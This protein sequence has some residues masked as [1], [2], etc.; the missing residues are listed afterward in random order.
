MKEKA[1]ENNNN[2]NS[3]FIDFSSLFQ[4]NYSSNGKQTED[5]YKL[6]INNTENLCTI[7]KTNIKKGISTYNKTDM[8]W[9][10]KTFGTNKLPPDKPLRIIDFILECFEDPTLKVLLISA[11]ISLIIGLLKEGLK[12]GWIEGSAIFGAVFIVTAISSSLNYNEQL[13][14]QK[15]KAENQKKKVIV[16]RNGI[17]TEIDDEELLVGDLLV[18][19]LGEIIS[20]DGIFVSNNYIITDESAIN[21]ESDPIKKA[22]NFNSEFKN[23]VTNFVC[24]LL[25]S[26]TQIIEGQGMMIVCAVGNKSFNGRNRELL[27]KENETNSEENL[28]P[29]KK[30]LNDL[31]DLI[32]NFGYIM[33]ALIGGVIILKDIIIK[34]YYKQSIFVSSTLDTFVNAF[35]LAIT[36]IV[37]AI[38]EGLPMAV[39]ISL[40][41][42]LGQMKKEKNLVKNLNSSETMGNVNNICT[43]KT[44]TLTKGQMVVESF[45]FKGKDYNANDFRNLSTQEKKLFFENICNNITVVETTD[46]NGNL[47]LNGDMTEK[48]LY[49]YMIDNG[50]DKKNILN[51]GQVNK[52]KEKY[53]LN[54]N[55][56]NKFMCSLIRESAYY[57]K[58]YLK[59]AHEKV[60]PLLTSIR[61]GSTVFEM[62]DKYKDEVSKVIQKYS[63]QSK[64]TLIFASKK[65]SVKEFNNS[66]KLF[67]EK[68]IEFYK[69]LYNNLTFEYL[70][71]IRDQLRSEVPHSVEMCHKA[72]IKVRM[73]TGDNIVTA[74]AISKDSNIINEDQ[75]NEA[76]EDIDKFRDICNSIIRPKRNYSSN[77]ILNKDPSNNISDKTLDDIAKSDFDS[78][79]A[80]EGEQF[81]LLSGN[82]TKNYDPETHKIKNITLNDVEMFKKIT[83]RLRVIARAT[84]EDKF[85]LVFGLK[86]LG[87]IIA[88]TGDGTNDAPALKEAH[89]GFAMGIRGTD[90]A[91]QAAD[92]LLLDDSF[93]S[94]ITACKFGR[95][96][97]DSIRKFVQ[98]QLTT[99]IVAVFMTLLGGIILKDSPLNAIQM[100]WVNLIMDSFASLA[101]AT[102]KPNDKLLERK[103]YKRDSSILTPFMRANILS[104]GIFQ[105][106][107]LLFIIFKGDKLFGVNS[108]RELEHYEWNNEHGYHFTI[109]FDVF[110]FLQVF[111]SINAR[112]LN[113]KEVNIFEGIKDNIYYIL[114][115]SFIVFGQIILVTFGGRAVRTQPLSILQHFACALIASLSL[116]IGHIVKL[117]PFDMSEKIVKTKEEIDL[118]NEEEKIKKIRNEKKLLKKKTKGPNLTLRKV[119]LPP[120]KRQIIYTQLD[121]KNKNN[122]IN[123]KEYKTSSS[124]I[125]D[126]KNMTPIYSSRKPIIN[127]NMN[128]NSNFISNDISSISNSNMNSNS[129]ESKENNNN[130][131]NIKTIYSYNFKEKSIFSN[132]SNNISTTEEKNLFEDLLSEETKNTENSINFKD[133]KE[134][135]NIINNNKNNIINNINSITTPRFSEENNKKE[136]NL[137]N[138]INE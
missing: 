15:L 69:S 87:N 75:F 5:E 37:V 1:D 73:V 7:L 49:N 33:A 126:R 127:T 82:L 110:V 114:V 83:K 137:I 76:L 129:K 132:N 50:Y 121:T 19:K 40:A 88:V 18:L 133:N 46:I 35:I 120:R 23:G 123:N 128:K 63:K 125:M 96:V 84:P 25:I 131:T 72:G 71:G 58:L 103:P 66:N 52:D 101:L 65:I 116:G 64:R 79:I 136:N 10:I 138:N 3:D 57:Y 38:P 9:R 20:V 59:G 94:I 81:R 60:F 102:E 68:N 108:D 78:P 24:P 14:F 111:N 93:S 26:G 43:D 106:L 12:T 119:I 47:I 112:K 98:F 27:S 134:K 13:Q 51:Y 56:D 41:Y 29:L 30:Q 28:T 34:I 118:E 61:S 31:A 122:N 130:I 80:L 62:F 55:S 109:F 85:L 100:L 115:Q 99:N 53:V 17:E 117:I 16:I 92:I 124:I 107:I 42:S 8:E 21:G 11:V 95:N 44:G 135:E 39:A 89:V 70:I 105:I 67:R 32:G 77:N 54:F 6:L 113:Q 22:S 91:Q 104:Q 86:Q 74:L 97:Y 90:I 2:E 36:V 45:W 48:A 4:S